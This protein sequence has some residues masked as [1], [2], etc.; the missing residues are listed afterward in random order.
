M[1]L[2]ELLPEAKLKISF[3]IKERNFQ[4]D[5]HIISTEGEI[6]IAPI[7]VN[8]VMIHLRN[9]ICNDLRLEWV[10]PKSQRIHVWTDF[11]IFSTNKCYVVQCTQES[12]LDNRRRAIRVPI[13]YET[14]C[15]ISNITANQQCVV[16]DISVLGLR[17]YLPALSTD[18]HLEHRTLS[19]DIDGHHIISEILRV[20]PLE[21]GGCECGCSILEAYPSVNYYVNRLQIKTLHRFIA[22]T[23]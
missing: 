7:Y 9:S 3:K 13:C 19:L 17:V 8:D 6:R 20:Q 18:S 16:K 12:K 5:T 21:D 1:L 15:N 23:T 14:E 11:L 2:V 10:N 22:H 4:F